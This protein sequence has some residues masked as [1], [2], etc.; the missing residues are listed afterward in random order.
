[1]AYLTLDEFNAVCGAQP[2]STK[3]I[4]WMGS[5]VWKVGGKVYAIG[6]PGTKAED[7]SGD[8][9]TSFT[10]KTD[11]HTADFLRAMKGI[12]TAPHLTRGNWLKFSI[13]C[14]ME[15]EDLKVYIVQSHGLIAH[16]LTKKLRKE[17]GFE[18]KDAINAPQTKSDF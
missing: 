14:D 6:T 7:Q 15:A 10:I 3:V 11:E 9:P 5:H 13:D 18:A 8:T 12:G 2:H 16:S 17:L 1:M 4:Q